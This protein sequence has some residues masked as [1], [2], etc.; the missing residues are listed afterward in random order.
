MGVSTRQG[1]CAMTTTTQTQSVSYADAGVSRDAAADAVERITRSVGSTFGP[2]VLTGIGSFGA[3]FQPDLSGYSEPVLVSGT[4]GVGTKLKIAFDLDR[5]DTI[6]VDL[7]AMC[8]NDVL[9]QGARPLF[10]L[11]YFA[12]SKMVPERFEQVV[13]GIS[14]GCR[15]AGCALVGGE[16]AELPGF[17]QPGEY[18]LAGFCV[19][20]V[21]KGRIIEGSTIE[22]GDVVVGLPSSG[23]HSNG[24]SLARKVLLQV[25]RMSLGESVG[26]LGCTLGEELLRPTRIYVEPVLELLRGHGGVQAPSPNYP[27]TPLP[28]KGIAH[29]TGGG[30]IENIP[31]VLPQGTQVEIR[32]GA[33]REPAV[34]GLIQRLGNVATEEM[35]RTFNMGIGMALLVGTENV[36]SVRSQLSLQNVEASVIGEVTATANAP[37]CHVG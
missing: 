33:W 11:D 5:H 28:L 34:F 14:V 12:T 26:E 22:P 31:R 25:A 24:Y 17:Y 37:H 13:A 19:G 8:V 2:E 15:E 18:D 36:E 4:D 30:L 3:L 6:G 20:I 16:N 32:R 23:L 35:F 1:R 7:V 10:F 9:A 27:I 29:I 21:D